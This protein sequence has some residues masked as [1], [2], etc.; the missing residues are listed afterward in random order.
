MTVANSK[1]IYR[2]ID[3]ETKRFVECE[4]YA[5]TV[6]SPLPSAEDIP[7]F[8]SEDQIFVGSTLYIVSTGAVYMADEDG[9]F[10]EQ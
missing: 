4:L 7:G 5:D 3:G 10:V 6:P 9:E 2:E 8:T 1:A